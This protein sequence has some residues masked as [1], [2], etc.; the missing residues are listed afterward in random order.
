M[1]TFYSSGKY[2]FISPATCCT[3]TFSGWKPPIKTWLSAC[4]LWFTSLT[5]GPQVRPPVPQEEGLHL[6]S[7][8]TTAVAGSELCFLTDTSSRWLPAGTA[9]GRG[10]TTA[11]AE[12]LPLGCECSKMI[13]KIKMFSSH[14]IQKGLAKLNTHITACIW[15]IQKA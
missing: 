1:C 10:I 11:G 8:K 3:P 12:T 6:S 13:C 4:S 7:F 2:P 5:V 9:A 14:N 15:S